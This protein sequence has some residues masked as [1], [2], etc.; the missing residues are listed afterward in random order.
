[1][2]YKKIK[3]MRKINSGN[4]TPRNE[5]QIRVAIKRMLF[6]NPLKNPINRMNHSLRMFGNQLWKFMDIELIKQQPFG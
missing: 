2:R 3:D 5:N 1:M 6:D 4:Q